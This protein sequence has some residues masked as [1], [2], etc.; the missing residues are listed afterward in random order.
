MLLGIQNKL[1]LDNGMHAITKGD[2]GTDF[3]TLTVSGV[4]RLN[5][6][7]KVNVNVQSSADTSWSLHSESGFSGLLD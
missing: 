4:M 7:E 3:H 1:S 5:A 2:A 6:G